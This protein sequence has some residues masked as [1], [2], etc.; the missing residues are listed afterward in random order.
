[1][2]TKAEEVNM[3]RVASHRSPS[4]ERKEGRGRL[5]V[6][7]AHPKLQTLSFIL[8]VRRPAEPVMFM[9]L[10][11]RVHFPLSQCKSSR[12]IFI[13]PPRPL[14][15]WYGSISSAVARSR[16]SLK[17]AATPTQPGL[18][19]D[20]LPSRLEEVLFSGDCAAS[21]APRLPVPVHSPDEAP[22]ARD[23]SPGVR[24]SNATVVGD[25]EGPT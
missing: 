13:M 16:S 4:N 9:C 21:L 20:K 15:L 1:M 5:T 2:P 12:P 18:H 14:P 7:A 6:H 11:D 24:S 25:G 23:S 19:P 22:A 10:P 3:N 8:V 17:H